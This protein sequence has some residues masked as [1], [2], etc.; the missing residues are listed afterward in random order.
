MKIIAQGAEAKIFHNQ[1]VV[2][3]DRFAKS[4]RHP[5][6]DLSLRKFRTKREAKVLEK[7]KE[8]NFASP[9]LVEVDETKLFMSFIPGKQLKDVLQDNKL[10]F[11]REMGKKIAELHKNDIIHGDLTTSNMIFDQEIHFIDFGLSFFSM[12]AEDKA[13]DL[14]VLSQALQS[15]HH[16]IADECVEN[17]LKSYKENYKDAEQVLNRLKVVQKRGRNKKKG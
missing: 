15:K 9:E 11:S 8:I 6:I 7:L 4:Y 16:N 12:K 17:I 3:K 1:E 2:L 10:K 14:H 13:V 5:Q